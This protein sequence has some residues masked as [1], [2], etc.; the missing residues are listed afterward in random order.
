MSDSSHLAGICPNPLKAESLNFFSYGQNA[1]SMDG[2]ARFQAGQVGL[3]PTTAR[4]GDECSA[5][6]S[7]W[8]V[9]VWRPCNHLGL[10]L[11]GH[12]TPDYMSI[13]SR[14]EAYAFGSKGNTYSILNGPGRC[15][16]FSP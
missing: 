7:Y 8:P 1:A 14:D 6:L 9:L 10:Q 16:G 4:F 3:E 5:K 12:H 13:L 2:V 11:F 15:D